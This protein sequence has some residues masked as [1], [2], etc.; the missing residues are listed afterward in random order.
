MGRRWCDLRLFRL[1]P[2]VALMACLPC[3]CQFIDS[4]EHFNICVSNLLPIVQCDP[5]KDQATYTGYHIDLVSELTKRLGI[6]NYTLE[7]RAF[8][9]ILADL[10]NDN[11]SEITCDMVASGITRSTARQ[12]LGIKFTYPTYRASLGIMTLARVKEGSNWGFLRPLHWSVW[13]ATI[14]TALVVPWLVFVVES[15]ACHGFIHKGDWIQGL[16]DAT[17]DSLAALVNFGHYEVHSAAAR[18]VVMA[19]GFLVLIIINTYVANL[20]A[21]LTITQVDSSI[22]GLD[23]LTNLPGKRVVSIEVYK[24]RLQR[25]GIL[26]VIASQVQDY[27]AKMVEDL[28]AGVYKAVVMDEPWVTYTASTDG[29]DLNRLPQ[30]IEPFDYAFAFPKTGDD[31]L[32]RNVSAEVLALQEDGVMERLSIEHIYIRRSGCPTDSEISETRAVHFNQVLGLW[33]ILA[34]AVLV[35][36][37][38]LLFPIVPRIPIGT[39]N[40]QSS[41]GGSDTSLRRIHTLKRM[42]TMYHAKATADLESKSSGTLLCKDVQREISDMKDEMRALRQEVLQLIGT[43]ACASGMVVDP[44]L[45][46]SVQID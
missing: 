31:E 7:C 36:G 24:E 28:R 35:A 16:K 2:L 29:C 38:L 22:N 46:S 4:D 6:R 25:Q 3:S 44:L 34:F 33:I 27:Q 14:A 9:S 20:A 18:V 42:P 8:A 17:Y 45:E 23:D 1:L 39:Q 21:F 13:A 19:Y 32:V 43:R 37:L 11:K 41:E 12:E 5:S 15:L 40:R 10:T 26:P 30:T